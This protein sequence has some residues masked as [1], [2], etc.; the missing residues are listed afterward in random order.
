[1][2]LLPIPLSFGGEQIRFRLPSV[3]RQNNFHRDSEIRICI[4]HRLAGQLQLLPTLIEEPA[5]FGIHLAHPAQSEPADTNQQRYEESERDAQLDSRG[6]LFHCPRLQSAQHK[7]SI[8]VPR[9]E[10]T[11]ATC[12]TYARLFHAPAGALVGKIDCALPAHRV[13]RRRRAR[14]LKSYP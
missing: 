13:K 4:E 8:T 6:V 2:N 3:L 7:G 14:L 1:M 9:A 10:N 5:Y 12:G 11:C